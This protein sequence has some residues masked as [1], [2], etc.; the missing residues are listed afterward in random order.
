MAEAEW[1]A[2]V[3]RLDDVTRVQARILDRLERKYDDAI[4][5]HDEDMRDLRS[6]MK[7]FSAGMNK[8]HA[9]MVAH[10]DGI[11]ELR[12]SQVALMKTFDQFMRGQGRNG[13]SK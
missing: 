11:A 2:P 1:K 8:L 9:V 7:L 3:G 12:A 10:E 13:R 5:R 6:A 4:Q